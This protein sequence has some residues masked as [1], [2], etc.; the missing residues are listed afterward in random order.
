MVVVVVVAMELA[1]GLNVVLVTSD[2][3]ECE[4]GDWSWQL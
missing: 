3:G 4:G 1:L 2:I